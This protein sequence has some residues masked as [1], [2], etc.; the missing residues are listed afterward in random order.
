MSDC[1]SPNTPQS[2]QSVK[3]RC[4]MN[5]VEYRPVST[6]TIAHHLKQPWLWDRGHRSFFYCEDPD[7]EVIYFADDDSIITSSALRTQVGIKS[8][9]EESSLCYCFGVSR[10]DVMQNPCIKEYIV[11]QTKRKLCSCETSNPSGRCC[12]KDFPR[13]SG[14]TR[15]R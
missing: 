13:A 10:A 4:P 15:N 2:T 1:C 12:L 7:C 3:H 14:I 11:E 8:N 9:S 6:R 5:G